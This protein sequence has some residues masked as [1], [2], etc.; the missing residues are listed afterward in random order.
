[1]YDA[2]ADPYCYPGA[3]VLRNIPGLRE[4]ALDEFETASTAQRP[5]LGQIPRQTAS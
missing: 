3:T 2:V 4:A 5:L 1:M